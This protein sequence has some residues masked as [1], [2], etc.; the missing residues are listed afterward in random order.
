M[1]KKLLI[2][3]GLL[4]LL[5]FAIPIEHKYD[6]LFRF[7]SLT[8]IPQ[9]LEVSQSYE[10][11]I[12][13]YVSDL[14]ALALFC[15]GLFWYR[16]PLKKMFGNPLWIVFIC[17][18]LSIA[19]SPFFNYPIPYTRLL[20]LF[21]PIA[22]FSFLSNAFSVEE[23]TKIT[24]YILIAIVAAGLFQT[25][26]AI[27]QYFNQAPLGLRILG[28][29]NQQTIFTIHDGSRWLI[30]QLIHRT[31]PTVAVIRASGTF[32]HANVLGGF[33][34]LS[35]IS[36]Y[37][38]LMLSKKRNWLLSLTIPIQFFAL[39]I[40]YSRSALFGWMIATAIWLLIMAYKWGYKNQKLQQIGAV[41]A[42]AFILSGS[43]LYNQ[44]LQRGGV[45][46]YTPLAKDSDDIRKFH[47]VTA[48]GIIKD[49]PLLGLGYTQF[50]EMA[51]QYFPKDTRAYV[52]STAPHN[53]FLFLACETGLIS[54]AALLFFIGM[55][56]K[57]AITSPITVETATFASL[58]VGFIFIGCC[59]F[60]P[61]LF[62]HGKLMFFLIASLLKLST[63]K[64]SISYRITS[65]FESL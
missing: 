35:L 20:Q 52:C 57:S 13:F 12:Y 24:R 5:A 64:K 51:T 31:S 59:D 34:V 25:L 28:E 41:A 19:V 63:N 26:V 46:S 32:T 15:I 7:Y 65:P 54:V 21:T 33:M 23:D 49:H 11:K 55:L 58:L 40:T 8:L 22:L 29:T 39:S 45:I 1:P 48:L 16:I 14:I 6:K 44:Y 18:L 53:I 30:D 2:S 42:I 56:L 4:V 50:S 3:I 17:A 27:A 47:Q 37:A 61:I 38:L 43:L 9:G 62:Q 10:K 60:Y 36:T